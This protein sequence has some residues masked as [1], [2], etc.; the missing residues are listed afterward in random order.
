MEIRKLS[1]TQINELCGF[2]IE[3]DH[4]KGVMASIPSTRYRN[5]KKFSNQDIQ[6]IERSALNENR[7]PFE[8]FL[9][10][11]G[12][13]GK[14][15]F[16]KVE[17]LLKILLDLE[18]L[19]AAD[20]VYQKILGNQREINEYNFHEFKQRY[21]D[22]VHREFEFSNFENIDELLELDLL[23]EEHNSDFIHH[24]AP[25]ELGIQAHRVPYDYLVS[26]TR[27]WEQ[28]IGEGAFSIVFKGVTLR[29]KYELAIKKLVKPNEKS[30]MNT[31]LNDN[32]DQIERLKHENIID[33]LGY[34]NDCGP[35]F[36]C[37]IYP[38]MK[39]GTLKDQMEN[40]NGK[41]RL[42]IL[43][44][45]AKGL[46]HLHNPTQ[47]KPLVH[48]DIKPANILIAD[49]FEAKIA[50]FGLLRFAVSG[51]FFDDNTRTGAIGSV[52]YMPPEALQY[53]DISTK[54]DV[55]SLGIV[56]LECL[57]GLKATKDL[58]LTHQALDK[59]ELDSKAQWS[60]ETGNAV[61]EVAK[62]YCIVH[63]REQRSLIGPVLK[64]LNE[65]SDC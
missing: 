62:K 37:I 63:V 60:E 43:T 24:P 45:V 28:K 23:P 1:E 39:N 2:L 5:L 22:C 41:Q 56:M 49:D 30:E 14:N 48:R 29:S 6:E 35:G 8:K 34:S 40:L 61:F 53:G 9:E 31:L 17:H 19:T 50:D 58:G 42:T 21:Q 38:F 65:I 46:E 51:E 57:T 13:M 27:F 33:M 16:P 47:G 52:P 12:T 36:Q 25:G 11:W 4:W 54:W 18:L 44:G 15:G 59:I 26:I 64:K 20:F 55:Y 3:P 32:I 10:E 7:H